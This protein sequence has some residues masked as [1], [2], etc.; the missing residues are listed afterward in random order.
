MIKD[1][2][3]AIQHLYDNFTNIILL[4]ETSSF[5]LVLSPELDV[6]CFIVTESN[7][8]Q[9]VVRGDT[10]EFMESRNFRRVYPGYDVLFGRQHSDD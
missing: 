6:T 3:A 8:T 5:Q 4:K 10:G 1:G 9:W 2:R 7:G